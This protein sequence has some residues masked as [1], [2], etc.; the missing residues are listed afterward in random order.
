MQRHPLLSSSK[1]KKKKKKRK[2]KGREGKK[3]KEKGKRGKGNG[4]EREEK[5]LNVPKS[6]RKLL[7]ERW[8]FHPCCTL[9]FFRNQNWEKKS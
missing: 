7:W 4:K 5:K 9:C 1:K 6:W 3:K 2:G 8:K